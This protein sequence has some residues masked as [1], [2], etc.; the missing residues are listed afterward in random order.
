MNISSLSATYTLTEQFSY[1][2]TSTTQDASQTDDS[3]STTVAPQTRHGG[4]HRSGIFQSFLDTLQQL[5]VVPKGTNLNTV[6]GASNAS[7]ASAAKS[8]TSNSGPDADTIQQDVQAFMHALFQALHSQNAKQAAAATNDA[9]T[10]KTS[11]QYSGF[12]SRIAQLAQSLSAG[13][14]SSDGGT[15]TDSGS[16]SDLDSA[17]QQLIR[18]LNTSKQDSASGTSK[19]PLTL[20][21]FLQAWAGNMSDG[22]PSA[23]G[24][25]ISIAA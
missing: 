8:G 25:S 7:S 3:Q 9:S 2:T 5:G 21:S 18:D 6:T 15:G 17:F 19:Q 23:L 14:S 22:G 12:Q 10:S 16:T 24:N 20:Q 4:H 13:S 1:S 11:S